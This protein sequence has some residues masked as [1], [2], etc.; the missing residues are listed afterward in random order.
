MLRGQNQN[1]A[2]Y[3]YQ[4]VL[5]DKNTLK[6]HL[7]FGTTLSIIGVLRFN[8]SAFE[9]YLF[10]PLIFLLLLLG[11]NSIIKRKYN[12]NILIETFPRFGFQKR[13]NKKATFLD[14]FLG[15]T[16]SL[17]SLLSPLVMKSHK[18]EEI[19][20]ERK[21]Y[22]KYGNIN[23]QKSAKHT[24]ANIGFAKCGVKGKLNYYSIYSANR[25]SS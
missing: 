4:K 14:I 6:K 9:T 25:F 8:S 2:T 17:I 7:I 19:N 10:T 16:I 23:T 13:V 18:F 15:I 20:Y 12:R 1:P 3:R 21:L 24:A 11:A 22:K 5:N